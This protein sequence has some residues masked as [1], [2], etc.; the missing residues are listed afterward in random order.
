MP[1]KARSAAPGCPVDAARIPRPR[2]RIMIPMFSM[3]ENA[4]KRL[5]SPCPMPIRSA[6]T[7]V[8]RPRATRA[9]PIHGVIG[10]MRIRERRMP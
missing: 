8:I 7:A 1:E 3:L 9:W 6:G 10:P 4:R 2:A 5:S